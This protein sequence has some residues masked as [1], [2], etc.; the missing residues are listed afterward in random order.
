ML[1]EWETATALARHVSERPRPE[2]VHGVQA[3]STLLPYAEGGK[4]QVQDVVAGRLA[5]E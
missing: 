4:N 3:D 5:S 1:Q 2:L